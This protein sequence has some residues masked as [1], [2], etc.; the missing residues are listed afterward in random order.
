MVHPKMKT[1]YLY[2]GF[3]LLDINFFSCFKLHC[4]H[5]TLGSFQCMAQLRWFLM[6]MRLVAE[7]WLQIFVVRYVTRKWNVHSFVNLFVPFF[8]FKNLLLNIY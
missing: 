7:S 1:S 5:Y 4:L 3:M 6:I 8:S 2:F